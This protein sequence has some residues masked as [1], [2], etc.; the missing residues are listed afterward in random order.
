MQLKDGHLDVFT[1]S[2]S[3][4]RAAIAEALG[5]GVPDDP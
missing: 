4:H 2:I 1:E 3:V 5:N